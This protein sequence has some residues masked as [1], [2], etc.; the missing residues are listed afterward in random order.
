MSTGLKLINDTMGHARGDQI[1]LE[2]SRILRS[3]FRKTDIIARFGGD[4]FAVIL[5]RTDEATT[6]KIASRV[7]EIVGKFNRDH[8]GPPLSVSMGIATVRDRNISCRDSVACR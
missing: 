3:C 1:L 7:R 2:F 6:E 4:E 8:I 5:I